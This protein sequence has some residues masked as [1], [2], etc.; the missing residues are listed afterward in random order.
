MEAVKEEARHQ[1]VELSIFLLL[2]ETKNSEAV[3]LNGRRMN[4]EKKIGGNF[5]RVSFASGWNRNG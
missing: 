4:E 1:K 3:K 2:R 5:F